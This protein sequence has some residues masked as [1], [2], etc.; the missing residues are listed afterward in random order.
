MP[1]PYPFY[2]FF[3]QIFSPLNFING[4]SKLNDVNTPPPLPPDPRYPSDIIFEWF[5]IIKFVG[6]W[7]KFFFRPP[8]HSS[9][10]TI[11]KLK[12]EF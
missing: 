9:R 6:I 1:K 2:Q 11:L 3:L 4:W 5:N 10:H 8:F 12:C 7:N